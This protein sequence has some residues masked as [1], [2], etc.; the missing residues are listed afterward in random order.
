GDIDSFKE[1]VRGCPAPV[2]VAGGPKMSTE[3][4]LLEMVYDSIQAGGK[5]VAIGRNIFQAKDPT[6]MTRAIAAVV[7]ENY[8]VKEA[9]KLLK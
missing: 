4:E 2:V 1:V 3:I 7:H 6:K 5:G 9:L 8:N